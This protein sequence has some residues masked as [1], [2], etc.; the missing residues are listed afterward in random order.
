MVMALNHVNLIGLLDGV[1]RFFDLYTGGA[2][3]PVFFDIATTYPPLIKLDENYPAIREELLG[4]LA[5]KPAIPKYHELDPMQH[6]I[7]ARVDPD[8]DWKI[9]YLYA[10]GE[11]PEANR[12]RCPRTAA[13]LDE[14]PGLF[15][16]FFSILDAG[17]S[18]PVHD[19]P[20]R[21]YLRYHLGLVV[22]EKDPPTLRIKDQSYTWQEG[23]SILF[24]D[25][26]YH[27]VINTSDADRVVLIVDVRRPMP[28]VFDAVNRIAESV[29]RVVYGKQ[30]LKKLA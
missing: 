3:R 24:D 9:F 27:E 2:K 6:Y 18:I 23:R 4:L 7:S 13:I 5:D 28:L 25:S 15:Q 20:Y 26:W 10:M 8:K 14:I 17:K 12:A 22:P 16:A 21:G 11:K 1:N 30:I 29:M 19:G